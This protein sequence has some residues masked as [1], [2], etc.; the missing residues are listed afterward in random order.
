M[1]AAFKRTFGKPGI[2]VVVCAGLLATTPAAA[3]EAFFMGLGDLPGGSPSS[4]AAAISNNGSVVVGKSGASTG[5][6]AFRWTQEGGIVG[7]GFI[8]EAGESSEAQGLSADGLVVVGVATAPNVF[9]GKEAFRW[10]Q[11]SGMVGLGDFAGGTVQSAAFDA[12]GDGSI[13]V[14]RGSSGAI[15]ECW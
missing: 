13:V 7:L 2:A 6:E 4:F 14:G 15:P 5:I 1:E 9:A 8:P 3:S 11:Q 12:S 10:T